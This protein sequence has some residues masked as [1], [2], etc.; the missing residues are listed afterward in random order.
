MVVVGRARRVPAVVERRG[1]VVDGALRAHQKLCLAD[2]LQSIKCM[3]GKAL[4]WLHVGVPAP[5]FP[6]MLGSTCMHLLK[7]LRSY[8]S[9]G[10][11]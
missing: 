1:Q 10:G 5:G 2:T 11:A 9:R 3:G 6:E 7:R 4:R 8:N